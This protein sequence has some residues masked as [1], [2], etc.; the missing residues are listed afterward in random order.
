MDS[1]KSITIRDRMWILQKRRQ[2]ATAAL[3]GVLHQIDKEEQELKKR[4]PH[5]A[6]RY[7]TD[8]Y[9]PSVYSCT[10]CGQNVTPTPDTKILK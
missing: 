2:D 7:Y 10:A 9:E 6:V 5:E 1:L 3:N 4:C 8:I